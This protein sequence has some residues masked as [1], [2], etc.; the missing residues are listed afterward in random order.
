MINSVVKLDLDSY[1]VE[2]LPEDCD[3]ITGALKN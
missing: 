1:K 2:S 3:L